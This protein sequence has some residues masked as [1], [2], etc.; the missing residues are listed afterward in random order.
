MI[1]VIVPNNVFL[2]TRHP[3]QGMK[4]GEDGDPGCG[5][6]S[7]DGPVPIVYMYLL[8]KGMAVRNLF[9]HTTSGDQAETKRLLDLSCLMHPFLS[10]IPP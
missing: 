8:G 5:A 9:D 1:D 4:G 10:G 3:R 7:N 6:F 2:N